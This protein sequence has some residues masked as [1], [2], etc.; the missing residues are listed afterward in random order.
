MFAIV[1]IHDEVI[2]VVTL[3]GRF[4][5]PKEV[6]LVVWVDGRPARGARIFYP[7]KS[8]SLAGGAVQAITECCPFV[9]AGK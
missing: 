9:C 6:G 2:I 7:K 4:I 8:L 5:R 1:D 3:D